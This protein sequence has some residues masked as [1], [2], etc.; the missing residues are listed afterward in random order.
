M[1]VQQIIANRRTI[2]PDDFNGEIIA[3][4]DFREIMEAA[5]WA[6]THGLTEPWH[7]VIFKADACKTFGEI[8]ARLFKEN[9]S[10][11]HFLQKKYDKILHRADNCS[12]VVVC[13]N[14]R[15]TAKNIPNIEEICA[16]S[17]AIQNIL[18]AATEKNIATFWST[19]GMCHTNIFKTYFG[20]EE[21]DSVLGILYLG[22]TNKPKPEAKRNT[23]IDTKI[24]YYQ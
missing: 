22:Y 23:T 11:E 19:G 9:T 8:H 18:L 13:A 10:A 12:H 21:E 16:T 1:N 3:D 14:K 5:N 2:D 6:P 24:R 15:G 17:A 7:F 4:K 20:Y